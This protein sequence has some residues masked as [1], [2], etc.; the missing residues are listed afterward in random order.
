MALSQEQAA[1]TRRAAASQWRRETY[2]DKLG[3]GLMMTLPGQVALQ[4]KPAQYLML[5]VILKASFGLSTSC[6][7][8][9]LL[10]PHEK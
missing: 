4:C 3:K 6:L 9:P 1:M 7:S 10:I 5:I 8:K 2:R